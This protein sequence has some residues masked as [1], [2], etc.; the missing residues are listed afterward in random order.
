MEGRNEL[1]MASSRETSPSRVPLLSNIAN[2]LENE[3]ATT[4]ASLADLDQVKA[5]QI[6]ENL[7]EFEQLFGADKDAFEQPTTTRRELWSYYLYYNVSLLL[8]QDQTLTITGRQWSGTRCLF[9]GSV[10]IRTHK[11][12]LGSINIPDRE[13]EL[14]VWWMCYSLGCRHQVCCQRCAH[15]QRRL[16][17]YHDVHIHLLGLGS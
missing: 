3:P 1:K 5:K 10:S 15:C 7:K 6:Q 17:C 11:C 9:T 2:D 12:W 14:P 13:R 4:E 16:L 8:F